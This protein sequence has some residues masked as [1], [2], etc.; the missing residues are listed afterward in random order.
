MP[1]TKLDHRGESERAL[2]GTVSK[3]TVISGVSLV[4]AAEAH[5]VSKSALYLR[6]KDP[7]RLTVRDFRLLETELHIPREELLG[8]LEGLL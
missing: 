2:R 5:G 6:I 4:E 3:Y 1:R 8:S 7:D